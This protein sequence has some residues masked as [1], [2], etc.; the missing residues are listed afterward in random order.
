MEIGHLSDFQQ[1]RNKRFARQVKAVRLINV[2][3]ILLGAQ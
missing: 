3:I 1:Y 2:I